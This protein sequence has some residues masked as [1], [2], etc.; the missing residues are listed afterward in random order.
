MG[1]NEGMKPVKRISL[2]AG[3]IVCLGFA[4]TTSAASTHRYR[5]VVAGG[6]VIHFRV[7]LSDGRFVTVKRIGW[8]RVPIRCDQ[9][10]FP[11]RGGFGPEAF[12]VNDSRFRAWGTGGSGAYESHAKV[13]GSFRKHGRRAAGTLRIRG[14]L[15]AHHTGCDSHA[16]DWWAHRRS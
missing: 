10:R 13:V 8:Q 9:G 7:E 15:D 1:R 14:D 12:T 3:L 4:A 2:C 6:G 11:F 16:R 5:G